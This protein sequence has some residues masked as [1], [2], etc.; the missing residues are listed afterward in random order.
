MSGARATRLSPILPQ[1]KEFPMPSR[2][3]KAV[4]ARA[5]RKPVRGRKDGSREVRYSEAKA[6]E[7]CER[8][9]RGEIWSRIS[10]THGMREYSTLFQWRQRKLEFA[11]AFA[12]AR[13]AATETG[14]DEVLAV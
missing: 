4:A 2:S 7:V 14:A 11:E 5:K 12:L 8:I 9:G 13:A 3:S 6:R 10:D 1:L